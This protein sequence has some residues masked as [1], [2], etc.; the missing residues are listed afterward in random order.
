MTEGVK[1]KEKGRRKLD[2]NK[3]SKKMTRSILQG[4]I[5]YVD[6]KFQT[7]A[8]AIKKRIVTL[9]GVNYLI[10]INLYCTNLLLYACNKFDTVTNFD[11]LEIFIKFVISCLFFM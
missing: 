2:F 8:E 5:T 11:M 6:V 7:K 4:F 1:E 9:G 3:D 10:I